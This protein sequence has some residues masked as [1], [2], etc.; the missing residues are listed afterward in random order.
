MSSDHSPVQPII[1][2]CSNKPTF[3][4]LQRRTLMPSLNPK[5]CKKASN[6]SV[7]C[8]VSVTCLL[9]VGI[10]RQWAD[11]YR[12]A[13]WAHCRQ[14]PT[15]MMSSLPTDTDRHADSEVQTATDTLTVGHR[16]YTLTANLR[17][18]FGYLNNLNVC[19]FVFTNICDFEKLFTVNYKHV[20]VWRTSQQY[21][22]E[23]KHV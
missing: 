23:H 18:E 2:P 6:T 11:R 4:E 3:I 7:T 19:L 9:L 12:Q 16:V 15:R 20:C 1:K 13:W 8:L 17:R 14:I 22:T 10:C 5:S 21:K